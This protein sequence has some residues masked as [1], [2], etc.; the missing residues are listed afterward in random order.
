MR[1]GYTDKEL[2]TKE[3]I[4]NAYA[5]HFRYYDVANEITLGFDYDYLLEE[6]KTLKREN[7]EQMYMA[8]Y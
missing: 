4:W 6:K 1:G 2:D 3:K 7:L 8:D 5:E